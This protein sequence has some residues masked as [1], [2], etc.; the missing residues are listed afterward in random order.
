MARKDDI[1]KSFLQH[2]MLKENYSIE[3][4]DLPETVRDGLN[5]NLPIIKAIALIVENLESTPPVTDKVLQTT[6]TQFLNT[7]T[8]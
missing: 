2:D 1:F 4:D 7:A 8:I 3:S 5:S 6:I